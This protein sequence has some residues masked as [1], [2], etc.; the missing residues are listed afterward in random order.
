MAAIPHYWTPEQVRRLLD[1]LS[2]QGYQEARTLAMIIWRSGLRVGEGL[3][4]RWRD[5]DLSNPARPTLLVRESKTG[6]ARTVPL[7]ADLVT[8]FTNWPAA[9]RA[10]DCIIHLT[11]R[12]ADRH[13]RAGMLRAGLDRESPGNGKHKAGWH[14]LRHSAARHWMTQGIPLNEVSAW[15]GHANPQ[16]TLRI[17]LPITGSNYTMEGIP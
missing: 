2:D 9:K 11:R 12:T 8:L 14:S 7:H 10:D 1:G 16:V 3:A 5:V 17:Y 6:P 15:L 4:L 13:I